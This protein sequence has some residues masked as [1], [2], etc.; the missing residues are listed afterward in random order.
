MRY[1]Q[2]LHFAQDDI[3]AVVILSAVKDL[4][5]AFTDAFK[6]KNSRPRRTRHPGEWRQIAAAAMDGLQRQRRF[7]LPVACSLQLRHNKS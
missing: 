3:A 5:V 2:I 6:R 4:Y 1:V 7:L